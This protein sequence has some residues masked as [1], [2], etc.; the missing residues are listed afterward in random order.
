MVFVLK[1]VVNQDV[2]DGDTG[3]GFSF[4]NQMVGNP[5]PLYND[6]SGINSEGGSTVRFTE[7]MLVPYDRLVRAMLAGKI[8]IHL[9]VGLVATQAH[10]NCGN[11]THAEIEALKQ[12]L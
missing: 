2:L 11:V 8:Q 6:C 5:L 1:M 4:V 12:P 10:D 7:N 3:I 9:I